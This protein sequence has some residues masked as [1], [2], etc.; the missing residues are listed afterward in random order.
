[1]LYELPKF[2]H[3]DARSVEEAV[4]WLHKY[5]HKAK[6]IAGGT[7]LLGLMKDRVEGPKLKIP[8]VLV[9][10]KTIPEM[11]RISYDEERGIRIGA[12]VTLHQLETSEIINKKFNILSQ[13]ARQIGTTQ[14]RSVSTIGGNLCQRPR[15][16]YFRHPDFPCYEKGGTMCYAISGENRY[17]NSV[18]KY[19]ICA[20]THPSDMAPALMALNAD[21]S[22]ANPNG[23]KQIPLQNFFLG[24]NNYTETVLKPD[25]LITGVQ[26]P[27]QRDGAQQLF[28][29]YRVRR[30]QDFALSSVATV[31]QISVG[32]C[33]DIRIALGGVAPFPYLARKAEEKVRGKRL[34]EETI[35][36]A[37]EASLEVAHPLRM[38]RYK[39]SL[40]KALVRRALKSITREAAN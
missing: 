6:V 2:E 22:I 12:T 40:T 38:N 28:L 32:I 20:M 7:D 10:I 30:S 18:T 39:I 25:E 4:S 8:E 36:Q 9:N 19:G 27:E 37:A 1:L 33:E 29:K 5:S 34:N 14:L 11:N 35:S 23:E 24:P 3:V 15:C 26:V 16:I 17:D 31:A 13:A 21:A